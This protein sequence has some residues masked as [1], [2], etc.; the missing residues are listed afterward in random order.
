MKT[1]ALILI[2]I[3]GLILQ[4][5]CGGKEPESATRSGRPVAVAAMTARHTSIPA[6]I[7]APGTVQPRDRIV[8]SSQ[9]NGFVRAVHVRVGDAVRP[10]QALAA[11]DARDAESQ[12]AMAQ[13]GIEEAE[14]ALAEARRA[15]QASVERLAAA[16]AAAELAAQTYQRYQKLYESRSASPQEMDEVRARRDAAA[17]ELAS[18]EAMAAA[19][20]ERVK[21]VEA[22]IAQAR[23]QSGRA[24]VMLGWT[25]IQAP[26]AGRIVER[27]V[28]P[29]T[30][31]FPGT[32]L[33]VLESTSRPQVLADLPTEHA[34]HLRAGMTVRV[35]GAQTGDAIQ[36]RVAEIVPLSDPAT[37][38]VRFKADLPAGAALENGQFVRVQVPVGT[39]NALLVPRTAVRETGQLTGLFVVDQASRARFRLAKVIAY[40]AESAE[41]LSGL[42]P[43]ETVL[44]RLNADITD[45]I[46]VEIKP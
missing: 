31:I 7:D 1:H 41:V 40:D 42:E 28:D 17:A 27:S 12:K 5:G 6:T 37:H 22:R 15:Q 16:R 35:L 46:P 44:A 11:L 4:A 21:Q 45:G 32:P 14:A 43:G 19:A 33:M 20:R 26:A 29:G 8:L 18:G 38:S 24:D 9:L 39:R 25:Q 34:R 3:T 30:A 13:A 2:A 36:G 23:G 10:G